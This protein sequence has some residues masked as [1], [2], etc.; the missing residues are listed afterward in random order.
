MPQGDKPKGDN[1]NVCQMAAS[2][3]QIAQGI[4]DSKGLESAVVQASNVVKAR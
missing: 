1:P 3:E 4:M 2:D